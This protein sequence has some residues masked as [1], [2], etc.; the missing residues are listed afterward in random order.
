VPVKLA[1][2]ALSQVLLR[3]RDVLA[4]GQV[5]DDLLAH[6]ATLQE[7]RPRVGEAPFEVRYHTRV[8]ALLAEVVGVLEVDLMV[9]AT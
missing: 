7:P 4:A 9:C 5:G 2:R 1:N 8:S 3:G 6:P